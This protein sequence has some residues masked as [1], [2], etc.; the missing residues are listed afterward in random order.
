MNEHFD[1][2]IIGS[3]AGGSAA[4]YRLAKT[5]K[6]ILIVEKGEPLPLDGSTLDVEQVFRR[7][8]FKSKEPWRDGQGRTVTPEEYFNLGGKTKWY[9]A[10]LL[11]FQPHEFEADPG[12]EYLGWRI[13]Y[14]DLEPYYREAEERLGI[15]HPLNRGLNATKAP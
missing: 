1:V 4:A 11:R 15:R 9:G 8:A 7:A 10:A 14:A 3:G 13:S 2:I 12:H 6:R 5:G